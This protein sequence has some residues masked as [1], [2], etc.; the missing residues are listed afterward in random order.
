M[1]PNKV[2][3]REALEEVERSKAGGAAWAGEALPPARCRS[4]YTMS[5][6][7]P[8]VGGMLIEVAVTL[9]TWK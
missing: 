5:K 4:S 7:F 6:S 2:Q 1:G 3:L 9:Q 8:I